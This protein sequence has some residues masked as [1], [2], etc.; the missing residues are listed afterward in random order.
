MDLETVLE[1]V[2]FEEEVFINETELER[3]LSSKFFFWR[4]NHF[5]N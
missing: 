1:D 2:E 3:E 5:S 4:I